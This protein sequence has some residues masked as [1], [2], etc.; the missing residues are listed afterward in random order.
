MLLCVVQERKALG[1]VDPKKVTKLAHMNKEV[2][3]IPPEVTQRL[4]DNVRHIM[5]DVVPTW[6][7]CSC[8]LKH[9]GTKANVT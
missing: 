5:F 1:P 2:A 9:P 4:L 3:Q 8:P 7:G 6:C